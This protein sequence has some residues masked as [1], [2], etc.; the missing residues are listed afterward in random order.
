M[1]RALVLAMSIGCGARTTLD[2]EP[3]DAAIDVT[4]IHGVVGYYPYLDASSAPYVG[5]IDLA[6]WPDAGGMVSGDYH[7]TSQA[8]ASISGT[9]C[10]RKLG[11]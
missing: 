3:L 4:T 8:D 7:V 9:F 11:N 5:T 10:A 1:K 2:A 6:D